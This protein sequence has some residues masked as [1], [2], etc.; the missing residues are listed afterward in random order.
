MTAFTNYAEDLLLD[1]AFTTDSVTRPTA[2]YVA[3]HTADPG[4]TG[5]TAEVVV[6]TDADYVRKSVTFASAVSGQSL[7]SGAV[8]WTANAGASTYV[9][10][11]VS[12]WDASTAGNCLM[13]GELLVP[14]TQ[15]ASDT[16]TIPIGDLVAAL[17]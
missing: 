3:L 9:V 16:F 5:A 8:S 11:H 10:T 17:D 13:K 12:I 7:S 2:W 14:V 15:N 4:E 1:W 6:G